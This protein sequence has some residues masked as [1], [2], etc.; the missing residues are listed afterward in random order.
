MALNRFRLADKKLQHVD[1]DQFQ[2]ERLSK[3]Q[4][5]IGTSVPGKLI[6]QVATGC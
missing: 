6:S 5:E 2:A 3:R 1:A 4:G